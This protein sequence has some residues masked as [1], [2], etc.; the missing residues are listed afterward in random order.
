MKIR[1]NGIEIEYQ[2]Q[3]NGPCV[4]L[5]HSLA[6]NNAMWDPQIAALAQHYRVLRYDTR[7][8]GGS[9]ATPPPYTL[10][11][12]AEDARALLDALA[13]ER[14]HW[15]GLSL[16]GMIGETF[17]LQYPDRLETLVLCD[18]TSRYPSEAAAMWEDRIKSA[19]AS[20]MAALADSTLDRWFTKP[21]R[22]SHPD[23]MQKFA[24][25]IAATSH[26][27]YAGCG[28]AIATIN[29]TEQ[30]RQ[31]RLPTLVIVG[32]QDMGTP[33]AMARE[34]ADAIPGAELKILPSAAHLSNVEQ[35]ALFNETLMEFLA[36]H[37][38]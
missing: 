10:E 33:V 15:V 38:G 35:A 31:L 23:I 11:Q 36:R 28:R 24:N 13:I 29:L 14:T 21:Y 8:H 7:G 32:E 1:A 6:C 19:A 27:G 22:Q 25:A 9:T 4:T 3:G 16:G 2:I 37:N 30:L 18:T 34:I 17:A 20:G 5:S 26:A 12:L